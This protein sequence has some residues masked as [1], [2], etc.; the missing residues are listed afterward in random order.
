MILNV[1]I[2]NQL[3]TLSCGV[4][5]SQQTAGIHHLKK[6]FFVLFYLKADL[7]I[8]EQFYVDFRP[9]TLV[10]LYVLECKH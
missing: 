9:I 8:H 4:L 2:P 6:H 10:S 5:R 7:Y 3:N 1:N